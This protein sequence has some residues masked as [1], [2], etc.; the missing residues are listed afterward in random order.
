MR[1]DNWQE[2]GFKRCLAANARYPPYH[3]YPFEI[4]SHRGVSHA[5]CLVFIWYRARIA[6][7]PLLYKGYCTSSAHARARG[8]APTLAVLRH[9][10]G[11][12][13][14]AYSWKLPAYSWSFFTYS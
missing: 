5:F 7:A 4:V 2:R 3:Q 14:F 10:K 11:C 13:F 1:D 6:E 8:I 12:G 9:S